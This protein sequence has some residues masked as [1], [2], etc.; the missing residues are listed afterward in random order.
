MCTVSNKTKKVRNQLPVSNIQEQDQPGFQREVFET[1]YIELM[2]IPTGML[3]VTCKSKAHSS[4]HGPF[5][6]GSFFYHSL[7]FHADT[8]LVGSGGAYGRK[9]K[10]PVLRFA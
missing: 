6:T 7:Q 3:A 5:V 4:S 2:L 8:G 9:G 10:T 1:F